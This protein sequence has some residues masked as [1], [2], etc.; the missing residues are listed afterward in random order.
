MYQKV[1][2]SQGT[3]Q[4]A[5]EKAAERAKELQKSLDRLSRQAPTPAT[6]SPQSYERREEVKSAV[7]RQQE[8]ARQIDQATND[9]RQSLAE[10]AER[11]AFDETL[12]RR[13]REMAE[14]MDQIQSK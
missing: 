14:V 1:D 4:E 12:T 7:E 9:L 3:V 13:L 5:L 10:A 6:G 8:L 11:R 2:Q